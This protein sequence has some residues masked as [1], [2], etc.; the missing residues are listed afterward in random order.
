MV[1]NIVSG[2][3]NAVKLTSSVG[4]QVVVGS[5]GASTSLSM[6]KF[7]TLFVESYNIALH[8]TTLLTPGFVGLRVMSSFLELYVLLSFLFGG[9]YL[10]QSIGVR[11]IS[12]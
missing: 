1:T 9:Y 4:Q 10:F 5:T 6:G 11:A 7:T 8:Q 2:A 3:T 12:I